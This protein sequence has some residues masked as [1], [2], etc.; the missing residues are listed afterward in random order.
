LVDA[1][2]HILLN[3]APKLVLTAKD[4]VNGSAMDRAVASLASGP[5]ASGS[6]LQ[7]TSLIRSNEPHQARLQYRR[8]F[9]FLFDLSLELGLKDEM[10]EILTESSSQITQKAV[11]PLDQTIVPHFLS[12]FI[13][14]ARKHTSIPV[15]VIKPLVETLLRELADSLMRARPRK[16]TDWAQQ[17]RGCG[18]ADCGLMDQFLL[19]PVR[20][21]WSFAVAQKRRDHVKWRLGYGFETDIDSRRTP[22]ILIV[23]KTD[24]NY[25]DDFAK[26]RQQL[27]SLETEL[28]RMPSEYIKEMLGER[29][30]ELILLEKIKQISDPVER[31]MQRSALSV[32][33][34]HGHNIYAVPPVAGVKRKAAPAIIDL[35]N[36]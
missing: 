3:C 10:M 14:V 24:L 32:R 13:T 1:Y 23:K 29:Y 19:D 11:V 16:P 2:R 7:A 18:C 30:S 36:E 6:Y 21:S 27:L 20:K 5:I 9:V 15:L 28:A 34:T 8:E 4:L 12:P 31:E 33:S 25:K 35:L 17:A 22:Y 26:W